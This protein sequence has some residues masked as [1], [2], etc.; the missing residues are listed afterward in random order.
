MSWLGFAAPR[1]KPRRRAEELRTRVAIV[2]RAAGK[3]G[4]LEPPEGSDRALRDFIAAVDE[5]A[6]AEDLRVASL[7]SDIEGA[8]G[9]TFRW[10]QAARLALRQARRLGLGICGCPP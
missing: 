10:R 4:R 1:Q 8:K 9:A 7:P 3:L 5:R 2:Q 6:A